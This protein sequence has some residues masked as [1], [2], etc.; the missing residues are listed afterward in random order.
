MEIHTSLVCLYVPE[1]LDC[2]GRQILASHKNHNSSFS[3]VPQCACICVSRHTFALHNES[4]LMD[5]YAFIFLYYHYGNLGSCP[6]DGFMIYYDIRFYMQNFKSVQW[7][8]GR[9][10]VVRTTILVLICIV[11]SRFMDK[12]WKEMTYHLPCFL[13]VQYFC[14]C[15]TS[16]HKI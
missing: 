2:N 7:K 8:S 13:V 3:Q 11:T 16:L 1:H 10:P 12:D 9:V 14:F 5:A 6:L 15:K 4:K